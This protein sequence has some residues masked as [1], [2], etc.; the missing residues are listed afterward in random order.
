MLYMI[1]ERFRNGD[2]LPVYRRDSRCSPSERGV[3]R[4]LGAPGEKWL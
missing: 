2:T 4:I 1:V 3:G